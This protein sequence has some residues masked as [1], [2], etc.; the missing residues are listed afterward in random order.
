MPTDRHITLPEADYLRILVHGATAFELVRTGLELD[1]FEHIEA[2]G[3]LDVT[4]AAAALG[5]AG[6][7]ARVL[8]LGLTSLRL[9][10]RHDGRYVNTPLVREKL[11]RDSPRYL[12]ALIDVQARVI[13]AAMP[14]LAESVRRDTNVGLRS[15]DGPGGTLYERLTAHPE[16]QEVFYANMGDASRKS[17]ALLLDGYDFT[18]VRNVLDL[19]G[20]DGANSRALLARYPDLT[21][22]LLDHEKVVG[23]ARDRTTDPDVRR[24]MR[25]VPGEMFRDPIPT[26]HDAILICHIFEIWALSR[27]VELLRRCHAALPE[28]GA[29][30]IY[31]FVSDDAGTGPM[32]AGLVSPYFLTL[33]SGEGMAYSAADM[34]DALTEAGFAKVERHDRLGYSHALV[35]GRK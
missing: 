34:A 25:F 6:Q 32:S 29:C 27:S 7:P 8:L 26:G 35:V 22:T 23:I 17:V 12:G 28:G 14:D 16:L 1:L 13:N 20:G 33:A 30:L 31:N 19:G 3:G 18:G 10:E 9:L 15:I 21:A 2:A 4:G 11:L 5:V 24:R